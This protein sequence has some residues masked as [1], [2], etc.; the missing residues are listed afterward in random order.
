MTELAYIYDSRAYGGGVAEEG[1]RIREA[2]EAEETQDS[3]TAETD[4]ERVQRLAESGLTMIAGRIGKRAAGGTLSIV[5][6]RHSNGHN[7]T[8]PNF[9]EEI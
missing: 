2:T 9:T 8:T 6:K 7:R 4:L 1:A 3:S 5:L